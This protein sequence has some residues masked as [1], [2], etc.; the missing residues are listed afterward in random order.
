[1]S[2]DNAVLLDEV[3]RPAPPMAPRALGLILAIVVAINAVFAISFVLRGA[4]PVMPFL[5]VDVALL[6]WAFSAVQRAAKRE[7]HV[8]LTPSR[9]TIARRAPDAPM[10]EIALNP[11][12]VRV[13]M[14]DPPL[15]GSQLILWSHGKGI[16][17]GS[18]LPPQQRASFA[19]ALKAALYRARFGS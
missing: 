10:R 1:M 16:L 5:G 15:H 7:E 19:Q 14:D 12:W 17:L 6:A 8:V 18:F 9:L 2:D 11:Y 13:A 3:L 4:W